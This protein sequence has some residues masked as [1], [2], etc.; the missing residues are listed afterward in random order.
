MKLSLPS[1]PFGGEGG[2]ARRRGP[3]VLLVVGVRGFV[4]ISLRTR[5]SRKSCKACRR[6]ATKMWRGRLARCRGSVPLPP[7][8]KDCRE[9]ARAGCPRHSG[10]D[11]HDTTGKA[12]PFLTYARS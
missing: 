4:T 1:P 5:H 3:H 9:K 11:A 8:S 2:T 12:P 6:A 10:R 7:C